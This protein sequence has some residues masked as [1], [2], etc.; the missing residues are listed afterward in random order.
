MALSGLQIRSEVV[1]GSCASYS[2]ESIR[3]KKS[4]AMV[5]L[6]CEIGRQTRFDVGCSAGAGAAASYS[7]STQIAIVAHVLSLS[8]VRGVASNWV[9]LQVTVYAAHTRF[10]VDVAATDTYS[11]P[12]PSY[13]LPSSLP[14]PLPLSLSSPDD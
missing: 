4:V 11:V 3:P 12:V 1:V 8:S 2:C 6:H 5:L 14:L 7:P 13:A 9:E 10:E